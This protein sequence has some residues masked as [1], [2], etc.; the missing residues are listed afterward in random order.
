MHDISNLEIYESFAR[1]IEARTR[2]AA[3]FP[4]TSF[5]VRFDEDSSLL[6]KTSGRRSCIKDRCGCGSVCVNVE[7]AET[8]AANVEFRI[9]PPAASARLMLAEIR[10]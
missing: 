3:K 9:S 1:R 6:S 7:A 10:C 5:R 4:P 8:H 2:N